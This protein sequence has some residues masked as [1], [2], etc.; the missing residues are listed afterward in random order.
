[1]TN[2]RDRWTEENDR[3]LYDTVMEYV[4]N[5]DT[6]SSAFIKAGE[7]LGR[8]PSACRYRWNAQLKK[9]EAN[10][11]QHEVLLLPPPM[12]L[13]DQTKPISTEITLNSIILYL[14]ELKENN[15]LE[16]LLVEKQELLQQHTQL[17]REHSKLMKEYDEKKLTFQRNC[18]EYEK[19]VA[20]FENAEN[21]LK[22][23]VH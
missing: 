13:S 23:I 19:I 6:K 18:S 14:Q 17:K 7:L 8:T 21:Q 12:A 2:R 10:F 11:K 5:G 3:L 4:Q 1:M 22:R 9:R 16:E 20:I 15:P